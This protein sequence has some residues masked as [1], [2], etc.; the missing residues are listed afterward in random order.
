MISREFVYE[1]SNF[2]DIKSREN[3]KKSRAHDIFYARDAHFAR[4]IQRNKTMKW[5]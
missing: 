4:H 3:D 5:R 2:D 1:F